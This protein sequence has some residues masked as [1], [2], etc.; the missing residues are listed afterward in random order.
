MLQFLLAISDSSDHEKIKR[1]YDD[2]QFFMLKYA[3]NKLKNMGRRNY[4]YE[5]EDVVQ[6]SFMRITRYINNI[7]FSLGEMCVKNYVFSILNNEICDFI[8]ENEEVGEFD[9]D[10]Y[11][12]AE[13]DFLAEISIKESYNEVVKAIENLDERYSMTL[14]L[15]YCKEMSV[16]S[17]SELMGIS[18]KTVYTRIS[19]GKQHLINS[20]KGA[21]VNE[22]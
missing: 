14:F 6:N 15:F 7:D 17:I 2:Y 20:L 11:K 19:R 4:F 13:Y 12:G 21:G 1:I 8:D 5:A 9:E 10:F 18:T 16:D 3:T 22:R